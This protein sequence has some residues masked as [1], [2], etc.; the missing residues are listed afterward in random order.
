[1]LRNLRFIRIIQRS[2]QFDTFSDSCHIWDVDISATTNLPIVEAYS[3]YDWRVVFVREVN[4]E[5]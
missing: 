3:S 1:M 2:I 4:L 5:S